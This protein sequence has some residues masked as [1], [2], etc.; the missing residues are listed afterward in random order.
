M[1]DMEKSMTRW[2]GLLCF[3]FAVGLVLPPLEAQDTKKKLDAEVIFKKLD[4]NSDGLLHRTEFLKLADQFKD[5]AKARE[6]LTTVYDMID[7]DN[8]G[9]SRTQFQTYLDTKKKQK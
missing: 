9:L 1:T 2:I 7:P 4:A 3:V 8:K 6:K 5:K